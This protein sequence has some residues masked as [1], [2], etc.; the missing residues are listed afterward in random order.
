MKPAGLPG[1]TWCSP[2]HTEAKPSASASSDVL[3]RGESARRGRRRPAEPT[4]G[5]RC[6]AAG[7]RRETP[8]A[9]RSQGVARRSIA[10][11][12]PTAARLKAAQTSTAAQTSSAWNSDPASTMRWPSPR[13]EAIHSATMAATKALQVDNFNAE[14]INGSDAGSRTI[15]RRWK[16]A[17]R[18]AVHEFADLGVGASQA[19]HRVDQH[20]EEAEERGDQDLRFEAVAEGDDERGRHG[21]D[22]DRLRAHSRAAAP[23]ADRRRSRRRRSR[24]A[25]PRRCRA[26]ARRAPPWR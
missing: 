2:I 14:K 21:D 26:R 3:D 8:S 16:R 1:G 23:S 17:C 22:R 6:R 13:S 25:G 7:S 18:Q 24:A 9:R 15:Q 20:G 5:G 10:T 4:S 19:A 12:T 11:T